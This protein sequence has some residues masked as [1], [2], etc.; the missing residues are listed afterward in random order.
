MRQNFQRFK[1]KQGGLCGGLRVGFQQEIAEPFQVHQRL[2]GVDQFSHEPGLWALLRPT[3]AAWSDR[4]APG[5][6]DHDMG[7]NIRG[8]K[9][10][11]G[12]TVS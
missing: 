4:L 8:T 3:V 12:F 9:D 2:L 6:A 7:F 5:D 11:I 10:G 1:N